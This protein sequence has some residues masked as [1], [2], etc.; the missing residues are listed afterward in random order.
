MIA[1]KQEREMTSTLRTSFITIA[2]ATTLAGIAL[3][4]QGASAATANT[5]Y[6]ATSQAQTFKFCKRIA[7]NDVTG[8]RET[9]ARRKKHTIRLVEVKDGGGN[10]GNGGSGGRGNGPK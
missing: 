1:T 2:S 3:F 9:I 4:S 5:N 10:G 6:S 7:G 8:C